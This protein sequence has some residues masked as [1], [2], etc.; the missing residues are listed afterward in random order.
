MA[1]KTDTRR[2][3]YDHRLRRMRTHGMK[4]PLEPHEHED[5][6]P[7]KEKAVIDCGWGRLLFGQTFPDP[8]S[9]VAA[10]HA[11]APDR[12]DIAF[13]IRDPHVVL[14]QAPQELFLDP[15]HTYRLDLSTYRAGRRQPKGFF[16]RRLSSAD[17][18]EAVNR[19]YA[20]H[21]MVPV[22][23]DF[24]WSHR[25]SRAVTCLVAEDAGT[26]AVI[27]SSV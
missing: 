8:E 15:S 13:Y 7:P 24:F 6:P 10:L 20:L 4:P 21:R 5:V 18:A 19:I 2:A 22:P 3:A 17:D 25:D 26:G 27:I 9:L 1:G 14:A 16:V 11:E 12:R 23:P